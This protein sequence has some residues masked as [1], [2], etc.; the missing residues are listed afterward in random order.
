M[1]AQQDK[2]HFLASLDLRTK[3]LLL[4]RTLEN[5]GCQKL[6]EISNNWQKIEF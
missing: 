1:K 4:S 3:F 6:Q 2:S 5:S